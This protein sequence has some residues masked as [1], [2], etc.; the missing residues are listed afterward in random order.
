M[1]EEDENKVAELT[2]EKRKRTEALMVY[3]EAVYKETNGEISRMPAFDPEGEHYLKLA[4][5]DE[6]QGLWFKIKHRGQQAR[7]RQTE[8][9]EE[10]L[11]VMDWEDI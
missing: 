2:I 3:L 11:D 10:I 1:L 9:K 5:E 8:T 6:G 4:I 7:D